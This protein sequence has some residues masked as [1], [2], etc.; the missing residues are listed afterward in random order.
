MRA[1][2]T[3]RMASRHLRAKPSVFPGGTRTRG[4]LF[5]P[6]AVV[7]ALALGAAVVATL[8]CPPP[9][10]ADPVDLLHESTG[11]G[12]AARFSQPLGIFFDVTRDECY[13]ADTGNHQIV[14][15]D[16]EGMPRYRFFH[17]VTQDGER[18]LG[19]PRSVVVDDTGR[20]FVTDV[21]ASYVDVLDHMG[22]PIRKIVPP[23][24]GCGQPERFG[25]LALGPDNEVYATLSCLDVQVVVIDADLNITRALSL[26]PAGE[27]RRCITGI[28]VHP[29]G[30]IYITDPCAQDMIQVYDSDGELVRGFGQHDSGW[31]NFSH[32]AG[33]V[34]MPNKDMW[35]V[36]TIRQITSR[37]TA[38][39]EFVSYFGGKGDHPGA[40]NYPTG[41]A[42]D[43]KD[44]LFVLERVG[45]RYQCFRIQSEV[46]Q[47]DDSSSEFQVTTSQVKGGEHR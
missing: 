6:R 18:K 31:E 13:V 43:G 14:V 36:D 9:T 32:P 25:L 19:E 10:G 5:C 46:S 40:F 4:E 12:P 8:A 17:H 27:T 45:N 44:R 28:A 30:E 39:G 41:L 22:R 7:R 11:V 34:V 23:A 24:D 15:C 29:D 21:A 37:F 42:T 20:I 2:K 16:D 33:I 35:I 3:V 1:G 38:D 26:G 47:E